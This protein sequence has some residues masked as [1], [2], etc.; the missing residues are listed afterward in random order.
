MGV[1]TNRGLDIGFFIILGTPRQ[2]LVLKEVSSQT[3]SD[4]QF[5]TADVI[6]RICKLLHLLLGKVHRIIC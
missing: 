1:T 4:V 3:P 5:E 6:H 2:Y